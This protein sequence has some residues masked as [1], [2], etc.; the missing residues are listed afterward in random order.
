M[1]F[2]FHSHVI[3]IS[4]ACQSYVVRI[5]LVCARMLS[6][7]TC[8][9]FVCH[10][11]VRVCHLHVTRMYSYVM[12][13]HSY[14][15]VCHPYVTRMY[16]CIIRMSLLC[17]FTMDHLKRNHSAFQ[18]RIFFKKHYITMFV[19]ITSKLHHSYTCHHLKV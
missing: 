8:M 10:S 17:G 15:F 4:F 12:V 9:S 7:C 19:I 3:R 2:A 18:L 1:P 16:S 14:V 6:V 11:Y 13:C 5:S